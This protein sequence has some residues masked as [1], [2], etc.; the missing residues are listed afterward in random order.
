MFLG[1]FP[2]QVITRHAGIGDDDIESAESVDAFGHCSVE[3]GLVPNVGH[4]GDDP[5]AF[6]F[7]ETRGFAQVFLGGCFVGN[8]RKDRCAGVDGDDVGALG[9]KPAGMGPALTA[10]RAGN[11]H[12]LVLEASFV[13]AHRSPSA[14]VS[15]FPTT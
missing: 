13:P 2:G 9:G 11:Q 7:N 14:K 4:V 8:I 5:A 6:Q 15:L 1:D 12:D 10:G 3:C